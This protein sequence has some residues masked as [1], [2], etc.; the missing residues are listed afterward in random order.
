MSSW[1]T[2]DELTTLRSDILSTLPS[3]AV[4][5]RATTT[6]DNYGY[7]S[8]TFAAVG[9]AVCRL[10]PM[11]QK[12]SSGVIGS[13]EASRTWYTLTMPY[14]ATIDDGDVVVVDGGDTLEVVQLHASHSDRL[15]KRATVAK[16][17]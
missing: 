11:N 9:T 2:A 5:K 1:I 14:D 10:D 15:V 17:K 8:E 6:T 7:V 3:T 12:D 4:V 13:G 16:V